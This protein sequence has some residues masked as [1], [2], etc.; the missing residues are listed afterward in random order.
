M[1]L[2]LLIV[3][4]VYANTSITLDRISTWAFAVL[5]FTTLMLVIYLLIVIFQPERF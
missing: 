4:V 3:P 1:S 5:G 2:N